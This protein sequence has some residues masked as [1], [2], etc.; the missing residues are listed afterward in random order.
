[1]GKPTPSVGNTITWPYYFG[2]IKKT[3]AECQLF[4]S[5]YF[6]TVDTM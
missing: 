2:V 5:L 1:M 6:L 4:I 3:N